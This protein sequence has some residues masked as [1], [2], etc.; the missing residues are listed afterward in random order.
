M[1]TSPDPHASAPR[2]DDAAGPPTTWHRLHRHL[3]RNPALSATT[4]LVVTLV[5]ATVLVAGLVMMVTPGPG[6][7]GI[8]AGL[9]ILA[10][11]WEWADR[12][13]AVAR[14]RLHQARLKA[15]ATDPR[16]RRRTT[17]LAVGGAATVLAGGAAY[18]LTWDW[19]HWSLRAWDRAQSWVGF[20]PDLPGM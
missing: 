19:P 11:E 17:A 9:A 7:L 18:L 6:L 4:K 20:L 5:G 14:R 13:L 8:V 15:A 1:P 2:A 10:T 16:V 3:H 12:L